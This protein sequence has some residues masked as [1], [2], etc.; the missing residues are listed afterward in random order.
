MN[1]LKILKLEGNPIE[2][3]SKGI[4]KYSE[5]IKPEVWLDQLKTFLKNSG[6]KHLSKVSLL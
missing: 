6:I 4:W 2:F 5:D 1:N 3:P